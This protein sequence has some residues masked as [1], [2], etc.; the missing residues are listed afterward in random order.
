MLV[1]RLKE[2]SQ[3]TITLYLLTSQENT[4]MSPD[5]SAH[6]VR[7]ALLAQAIRIS[8]QTTQNH[9]LQSGKVGSLFN[10]N[11]YSSYTF[12]YSPYQPHN[13]PCLAKTTLMNSF[14]SIKINDNIIFPHLSGWK[15]IAPFN[16][17]SRLQKTARPMQED[18]A[19]ATNC[20]TL[21]KFP[22]ICLNV[23]PPAKRQ[24]LNSLE[25]R[26]DLPTGK[27]NPGPEEQE[28][29]LG[30]EISSHELF[31]PRDVVSECN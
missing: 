26:Q 10:K 15:S 31:I 19:I 25:T 2:T 24:H 9:S 5:H 14:K 1:E 3:K 17:Q 12:F 8:L 30:C 22:S 27:R 4:A 16:P 29:G 23:G 13:I 28:L 21:W 18:E 20:L 11:K 6:M 7:C